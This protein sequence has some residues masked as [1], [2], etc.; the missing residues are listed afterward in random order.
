MCT[1]VSPAILIDHWFF[2]VSWLSRIYNTTFGDLL[3]CE[4]LF[5]KCV[6]EGLKFFPLFIFKDYLVSNKHLDLW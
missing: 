2:M 4:V 6:V 5:E 1:N 3:D